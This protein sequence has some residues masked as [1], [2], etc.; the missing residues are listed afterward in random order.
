MLMLQST[1]LRFGALQV[2]LRTQ[3]IQSSFQPQRKCGISQV[4]A[5]LY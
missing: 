2:Q 3:E 4:G 1:A 5:E